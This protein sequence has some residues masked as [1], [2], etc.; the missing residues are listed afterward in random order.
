MLLCG[1]GFSQQIELS[2]GYCN[3]HYYDFSKEAYPGSYSNY[4]PGDGYMAGITISGIRL[5]SPSKVDTHFVELSFKLINYKG[6]VDMSIDG[7]HFGNGRLNTKIEKMILSLGIYPLNLKIYKGFRWSLG[8]EVGVLVHSEEEII[9]NYSP[10]FPPG[11]AAPE[12]QIEYTKVN[13]GMGNRFL[14]EINVDQHWYLVPDYIFY[15]GFIPE[16]SGNLAV[17]S[18][19]HYLN[20]GVGRRF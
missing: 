18:Y 14:Y 4:E 8:M 9:E 15:L 10:W 19:R 3:N 16:S 17:F 2:G 12:P 1:F 7:S 20:F 5:L 6:T 13:L 11:S